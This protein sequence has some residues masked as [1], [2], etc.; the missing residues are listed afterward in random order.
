MESVECSA[1][2]SPYMVETQFPTTGTADYSVLMRKTGTM[3]CSPARQE[4]A[5]QAE[6]WL[7][8]MREGNFVVQ[9]A[10]RGL[11]LVVGGLVV[12]DLPCVLA[13]DEL[14]VLRDRLDQLE[15]QAGLLG[16]REVLESRNAS[17]FS[18]SNNDQW[19]QFPGLEAIRFSVSRR[20]FATLFYNATTWSDN[21]CPLCTK[22]MLDSKELPET[23]AITGSLGYHTNTLTLPVIVEPGQHT[24]CLHYR[25]PGSFPNRAIQD[26]NCVV[27]RVIQH[28]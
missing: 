4:T 20:T 18:L 2:A 26:W 15:K 12:F 6:I 5:S 7:R 14:V 16:S 3:A 8:A 10:E 11:E 21:P 19:A 22:L 1:I 25:T 24:V 23:R 28:N 27:M 9:K 17:P 13:A